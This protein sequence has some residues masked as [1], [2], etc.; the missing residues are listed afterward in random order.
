MHS[1]S[2]VQ[3]L[4][5]GLL[6]SVPFSAGFPIAGTQDVERRHIDSR[7]A[8]ATEEVHVILPDIE[9]RHHTE[10]QIKAK[11][12]AAAKKAGGKREP[13][14][15]PADEFGPWDAEEDE[16]GSW[17]D[18]REAHHTEA[19]IKAKEAATKKKAGGKREAHHT[20]AQIKAKEAA[21][22]KKAGG[23]RG[24]QTPPAD[25]FGPW[26][27]EED[28]FGSWVDKREAHHTEAQIK[29]KEAAT[30]KKASG[31]REPHHTEA[32]VKAKEAAAKKNA[33]GKREAHHTEAQIKAKEAAAATKNKGN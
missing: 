29:A 20:E 13:Q 12:A 8:V 19:Q 11:E 5:L 22:A 24:P 16:F 3:A 10:A 1:K 2:I 25:E 21:A 32:Q 27:A 17:V 9:A 14:T 30:K 4:F 33:G 15:P 7:S 28:E 31:K 26:D 18:K 23:K 6:T